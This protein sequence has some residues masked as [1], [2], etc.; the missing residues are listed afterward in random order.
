MSTNGRDD[1]PE[2]AFRPLRVS[3]NDTLR[4]E[5]DGKDTDKLRLTLGSLDGGFASQAARK[6]FPARFPEAHA[7]KGRFDLVHV[8]PASDLSAQL[9]TRLWPADRLSFSPEAAV[10]VQYQLATIE[11][12]RASMRR[13]AEY[14]DFTA[15][16]KPWYEYHSDDDCV[17]EHVI[18]PDFKLHEGLSPMLHQRVALANCSGSDGYGLF[19]EQ[20]TGKTLVVIG[21]VDAESR[22]KED[23][24]LHRTLIV[25]PKNVRANWASEFERFS[26]VEGKVTVLRGDQY[27]RMK[28]FLAALVPDS[29]TQRYTVM[30]CSYEGLINMWDYL[31][32]FEWD[33]GVLDEAHYIKWPRTK[34][35][36]K[37]FEFRDVCK[38]R[39]ALTGTPVCN[40][41]VDLYALFEFMHKGG[42]GFSSFEAFRK[43]YGVFRV[44]DSTRGMKRLVEVQ[45]LPFMKER[46]ARKSFI[47]RKSEA[48][49]DLPDKRY[50]ICEVEMSEEQTAAYTSLQE[51]LYLEIE[52]EMSDETRVVNVNNILTKL[53]RLSQ[54][55]SGFLSFDAIVDPMTGEMLQPKSID[56]FDPNN[57]LERLI[58]LLKDEERDPNGKTIVWACYVQDIKTIS[59]RLTLE[60][61]KHAVFYG[62]T[63]D[64]ERLEAERAFNGDPE[65][66]VFVGNPA[67]GGTGLNLIGYPPGRPEE[68]ETNCDHVVYYSQGWSSSQRSQSEDRAHRRGT[69]VS[70]RVTDL[71]VP[72]TIDEEIRARVVNKRMVALKVQDLRE[73][74]GRILGVKVAGGTDE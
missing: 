36:K 19:M 61:M 74:L 42:S 60:G 70:V 13:S 47:V 67:C 28:L 32:R 55:T 51:N 69:R 40:T 29:P 15:N 34:R 30:V 68:F 22:Q 46:L 26:S 35:A 21:R 3:A 65:C 10:I 16:R 8:V 62:A 14:H 2:S 50:D 4:V 18:A 20:G 33:L 48:L 23:G 6:E 53:L 66:R 44:V 58:E 63:G 25:A 37:A 49:P 45:N 9:I 54:I 39:M 56:R 52:R 31:G 41:P 72:K 7:V 24:V 43:F 5:L 59:A 12:Q 38:A 57:K 17:V 64:D 1:T 73:V 71:V 11:H 27:E